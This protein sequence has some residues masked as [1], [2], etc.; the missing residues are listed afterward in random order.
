MADTSKFKGCFIDEQPD[1]HYDILI[2][3]EKFA[4]AKTLSVRDQG[5]IAKLNKQTLVNGELVSDPNSDSMETL[6][7]MVHIALVSWEADRELTADNIAMLPIEFLTAIVGQIN[8]H[9][10]LNEKIVEDA[11]KN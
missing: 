11:E 6:I 9:Q 5:R 8:E 7:T 3:G 2:D 4:T 10:G 1:Y